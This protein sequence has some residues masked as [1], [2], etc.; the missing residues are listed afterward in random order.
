MGTLDGTCYPPPPLPRQASPQNLGTPGLLH[1][2]T[3]PLLHSL[4]GQHILSVQQF[5]KDQVPGRGTMGTPRA[6]R[7]WQVGARTPVATASSSLGSL[8]DVSPVQRGPHAAYD[9]AEGA[10]PRHPQGQGQGCGLKVPAPVS[11]QDCSR[12]RRGLPPWCESEPPLTVTQPSLFGKGLLL[13][14]HSPTASP[15][16]PPSVLPAACS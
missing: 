11:Q 8:V 5:T 14:V 9:G 12:G 4:V 13:C 1:P 10:E 6:L 7:I 2:Q 3:S 16:P 15:A